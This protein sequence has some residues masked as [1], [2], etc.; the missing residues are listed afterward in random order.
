MF[1]GEIDGF[2]DGSVDKIT[3]GSDVVMAEDGPL[4]G[5]EKEVET[6][7]A[8][9]TEVGEFKDC[10][11]VGQVVGTA[12]TTV[13]FNEGSVVRSTGDNEVGEIVD[14]FTAETVVGEVDGSRIDEIEDVSVA[15]FDDGNTE[16]V[17]ASPKGCSVIVVGI[18][19]GFNE[20]SVIEVEEDSIISLSKYSKVGLLLVDKGAEIFEK[21][22]FGMVVIVEAV[23]GTTVNPTDGSLV[24]EVE[25]GGVSIVDDIDTVV[26]SVEDCLD[27]AFSDKF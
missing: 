15:D 22:I 4:V 23:E 1:D 27:V 3:G 11:V 18:M 21:G 5:T 10:V 17:C 26:E 8:D 7:E 12:E 13:S 9:C 19:L 6:T 25:T 16:G 24:G 20:F 14:C 2:T